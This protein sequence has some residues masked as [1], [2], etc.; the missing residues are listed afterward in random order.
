MLQY[1]KKVLDLDIGTRVGL[2]TS[3]SSTLLSAAQIKFWFQ[4]YGVEGHGATAPL[5]QT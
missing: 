1:H 2:T 5:T 3:V 4:F